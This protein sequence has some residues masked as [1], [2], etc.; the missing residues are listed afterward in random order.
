VYA[1]GCASLNLPLENGPTLPTD[2]LVCAFPGVFKGSSFFLALSFDISC[3]PRF[4]LLASDKNKVKGAVNEGVSASLS[5]LGSGLVR[6]IADGTAA[7]EA[8]VS[9]EVKEPASEPVDGT[10]RDSVSSL[11]EARPNVT[12]WM[13]VEVGDVVI[14]DSD[15]AASLLG[16]GSEVEKAAA[17]VEEERVTQ[18]RREA[19][20]REGEN[21][22]QPG[23]VGA[24]F[25]NLWREQSTVSGGG[26]KGKE[27]SASEDPL[28]LLKEWPDTDEMDAD[29]TNGPTGFGGLGDPSAAGG[30]VPPPLEG[31]VPLKAV[32]VGGKHEPSVNGPGVKRTLDKKF[33]RSVTMDMVEGLLEMLEDPPGDPFQ[34][35]K[36]E[37]GDEGLEVWDVTTRGGEMGPPKGFV[38]KTG[39]EGGGDATGGVGSKRQRES[40]TEE[41]ENGL[42]DFERGG[43][44]AD[45]DMLEGAANIQSDEPAAKKRRVET[46]GGQVVGF[47]EGQSVTS[48]AGPSNGGS[49]L[50]LSGGVLQDIGS[51]DQMQS[52][53]EAQDQ[54]MGEARMPDGESNHLEGASG[55]LTD[56]VPNNAPETMQPA[57][58][59]ETEPEQVEPTQEKTANPQSLELAQPISSGEQCRLAV[60]R[61]FSSLLAAAN[62]GKAPLGIYR[63]A[64]YR[65][66]EHC[67]LCIKHDVITRQLTSAGVAHTEEVGLRRPS[68]DLRIKVPGL[69]GGDDVAP[70][71]PPAR[72]LLGG[73]GVPGVT[74]LLEDTYC[75]SLAGLAS[76]SEAGTTNSGLENASSEGG[77]QGVEKTVVEK[78]NSFAKE[79]ASQGWLSS[80]DVHFLPSPSEDAHMQC[81]QA[82]LQIRVKRITPAFA[83]ELA[84]DLKRVWIARA[85]VLHLAE[86]L[87]V[88]PGG[89]AGS[90]ELERLAKKE[91]SWSKFTI[92]GVSLTDVE[93]SFEGFR[94]VLVSV[95]WPRGSEGAKVALLPQGLE[96]LEKVRNIDFFFLFP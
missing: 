92:T 12:R 47:D 80:E 2:A 54:E 55:T 13:T 48:G 29:W 40:G 14:G 43:R 30:S 36:A 67:R 77:P 68:T 82:G 53:H 17:V 72:V 56:L 27:K 39:E 42:L 88:L 90:D 85:F 81:T 64:F 16:W 51:R 62:E 38:R 5:G 78:A 11:F 69:E 23:S 45:S 6:G 25:G 9:E 61:R 35:T 15:P 3:I 49:G 65:A 26:L 33:E 93:L 31:S 96:R 19:M 18:N 76:K 94:T 95:T 84:E 41:V 37:V 4:T 74:V 34:A 58:L 71:W 89:D 10:V 52:P 21:R 57:F 86:A 63:A 66:L 20:T 87:G 73:P 79:E 60:G 75:K 59:P 8:M 91:A 28:A 83:T 24:G 7:L 46:D 50:G 32:A 70:P 22:V 44:P 1:H